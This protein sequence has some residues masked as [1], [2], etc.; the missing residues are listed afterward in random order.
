MVCTEVSQ[1]WNG[2]DEENDVGW[3]SRGTWSTYFSSEAKAGKRPMERCMQPNFS[4]FPHSLL[5]SE[6]AE[7]ERMVK[8]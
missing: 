5:G 1:R 2:I 7:E 3:K 4:V 8:Q 6:R